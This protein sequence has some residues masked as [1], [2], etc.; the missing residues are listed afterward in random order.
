MT[1]PLEG[2]DPRDPVEPTHP[3][4]P[5]V[6]AG[7]AVVLVVG[8]LVYYVV[9]AVPFALV[10]F[11]LRRRDLAF[12]GVFLLFG[13]FILACGTTHLMGIWTLWHPDY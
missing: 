5:Y 13:V 7:A 12:P 4:W 1:H 2:V 11:V 10:F 9:A 3:S 8:W 6:A